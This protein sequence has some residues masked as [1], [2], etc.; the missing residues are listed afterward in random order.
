MRYY[1]KKHWMANLLAILP[2]LL[3][4]A[5]RTVNN[6]LMIRTFQGIIDR[7]LRSFFF[8][9]L[10]MTGTW[11]LLLWLEGLVEFFQGRAV[12]MMNNSVR[13]DMTATL[14]HKSHTD[15]H[16]KDTGE[17]LS[18]FTNDVSL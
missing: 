6:L 11:F 17:Y 18:W 3:A 14:L 13:R 4:S 9:M 2:G 8:W 16:G 10:M 7:D 1:L 15:F 12:R 5:L